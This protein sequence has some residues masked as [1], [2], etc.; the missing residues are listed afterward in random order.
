[1]E[2]HF[3]IAAL[4]LVFASGEE[5]HL[6]QYDRLFLQPVLPVTRRVRADLQWTDALE[7]PGRE[8]LYAE[9]ANFLVWRTDDE[10][11]R[12]YL[13][14]ERGP[15]LVSRLSCAEDRVR[16][17][18]LNSERDAI[19]GEF[20]PW[21]NIHL[22]RLLLWNRALLLH[23]AS[24]IYRGEAILF[25]APS[26]TGK[27]TQ[28]DLWHQYR[29]GVSD[30][31]G[32]RTVMQQTDGGW[33]GCGF[34]VYG[35]LI[36]CAQTAVPLRAVVV[37]RQAKEDRIRPLSPMEQVMYLYSQCTVMSPFPEDTA[38]AMDLLESLTRSVTV[39]GLDCTM[40]RSAVDVLHRYLY[41]E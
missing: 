25:S 26:G 6:E 16:I 5:L 33:Y 32:D 2:L 31:N 7:T 24:I 13:R 36:R 30:L 37:L 40:E 15:A 20:R 14:R 23:S 19:L 29:E 3:Y 8:T 1:M 22:E 35:S 9:T 18:A 12:L 38:A 10:E 11:V 28:T 27:T 34:P 21:F 41:G 17:S 4:E 39:V